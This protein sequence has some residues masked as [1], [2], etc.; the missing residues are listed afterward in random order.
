MKKNC[1]S[2]MKMLTCKEYGELSKDKS[3][4]DDEV[5]N[6]VCG[7]YKSRFIEYPISVKDIKVDWDTSCVLRK[8]Q[9]GKFVAV[10]PCDEKCDGKTFLGLFLGELPMMPNV[11]YMAKT[12]TIT[13]SPVPNPAMFVFELNRIIF[14]AESWWHTIEKE[15][16]LKEITDQSIDNVW[17]VRALKSLSGKFDITE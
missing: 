10:R 5:L 4:F 13:V 8:E 12:G 1:L 2:C 14:G 17:Y 15:D 7:D 6:H 11:S 3:M 9:I 16:D